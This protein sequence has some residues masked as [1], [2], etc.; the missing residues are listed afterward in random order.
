V[1]VQV[2]ELAEQIKEKGQK[3]VTELSELLRKA[4]ELAKDD[5]QDMLT[6][7][8]AYKAAGNAYQLLNQFQPALE[9]YDLAVTI[10]DTLNEPIEL[11]RT[12]HAKVGMLAALAL[13]G[14]RTHPY[15]WSGFFWSGFGSFIR[16]EQ[17][18]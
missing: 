1:S 15:F 13:R 18:Q 11:G 7:A 3:Y 12:L 16:K 8:L 4:E 2:I 9:K 14:W 6:R 17:E 5:T 10:L